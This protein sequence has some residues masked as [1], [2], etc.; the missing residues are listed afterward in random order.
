MVINNIQAGWCLKGQTL[1]IAEILQEVESIDGGVMGK[2]AH[3]GTLDK[4]LWLQK[5]KNCIHLAPVWP[6]SL[7]SNGICTS[8]NISKT[9]L[10]V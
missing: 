1:L 7:L 4:S 3:T 5:A 6:Q 2:G 9:F 10:Q 8:G